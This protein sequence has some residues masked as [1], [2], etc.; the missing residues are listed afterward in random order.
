MR[1]LLD[2]GAVELDGEFF[3]YRGVF[4]VARPVARRVPLLLGAMS[5]PLV[6]RL[7]GELSDRFC[8]AGTPEEV[9]ER[10]SRE[11]LPAGFN[12]V[13]LALADAEIPR[14]RAGTEIPGLPTLS[15]QVRLI[16]D[17]VIPLVTG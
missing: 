13:S 15:E 12:H 6:L 3:R 1:S 7:A 4:T 9:A 16:A 11:F 2:T 10:I 14:A 17:R 8:V 5:G